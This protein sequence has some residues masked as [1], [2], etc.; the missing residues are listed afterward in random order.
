VGGVAEK[1]RAP[2]GKAAAAKAAATA[3]KTAAAKVKSAAKDAQSV[4][5]HCRTEA[6][7]RAASQATSDDETALILR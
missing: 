2:K 7:G 3:A 1:S 6:A 5:I 4:S